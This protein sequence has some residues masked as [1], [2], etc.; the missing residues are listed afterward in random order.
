[1]NLQGI[2]K[3]EPVIAAIIVALT[4]GAVG[5]GIWRSLQFGRAMFDRSNVPE[6]MSGELLEGLNAVI[7]RFRK[8]KVDS[9]R[10]A[11]L[12]SGSW[13]ANLIRMYIQAHVRRVLTLIDAG[14]AELAV[15]RPLVVEMCSRAVYESVA[16]FCDFSKQLGPLLDGGDYEK[17][18]DF[19]RTRIFA[20]RVSEFV[21]ADSTVSATSILTQIDKLDKVQPRTRAAY[22]HL[23]D[24]VHPN[25]LGTVIYFGS[26]GDDG[27][28]S[29]PDETTSTQR[30]RDSLVAAALMLLH[31]DMAL[32]DLEQRLQRLVVVTPKG[33]SVIERDQNNREQ[34]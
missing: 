14:N 7:E 24:I 28:M 34:T 23:S 15:G 9:I 29:L 5:Y 16:C 1:M 6:G 3:F 33:L 32:H 20:T 17:V 22:D 8:L 19:L 11:G 26:L 27:V 10:L 2:E 21:T 12:G 4:L 18:D 25:A 31:F 30:A 13:Y